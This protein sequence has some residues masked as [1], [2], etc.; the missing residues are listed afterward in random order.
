[1][2]YI[3]IT[4]NEPS[5]SYLAVRPL[6]HESNTLFPC[7]PYCNYIILLLLPLSL[8]LFLINKQRV[9]KAVSGSPGLMDLL[10]G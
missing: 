9:K 1:M 6:R 10:L 8:L 3:N 2:Y 7:N 5:G 4:L